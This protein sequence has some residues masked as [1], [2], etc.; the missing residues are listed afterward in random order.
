M[1]RGQRHTHTGFWLPLGWP[2]LLR[3]WECLLLTHN[4]PSS[5]EATHLLRQPPTQSADP[6]QYLS[7]H[8][9]TCFAHLSLSS[10]QSVHLTLF[11]F[12]LHIST[13]RGH[14]R[15]K[16]FSSGS[17]CVIELN[18][19]DCVITSFILVNPFKSTWTANLILYMFLQL[20]ESKLTAVCVVSEAR[21]LWQTSGC[22]KRLIR[23]F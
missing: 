9:C 13:F 11:F 23:Y 17:T 15:S 22:L 10:I 20:L 3:V 14:V 5:I 19:F 21:S 7:V 4:Q 8:L 1:C 2:A 12:F 16:T 6:T 18:S